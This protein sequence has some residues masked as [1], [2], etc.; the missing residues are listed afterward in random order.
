MDLKNPSNMENENLEWVKFKSMKRNSKKFKIRRK[1]P[2]IITVFIIILGLIII[3]FIFQGQEVK[4]EWFNDSWMY[5]QK[6]TANNNSNFDATDVPYK[7]LVDT[8][9]L[10]TDGKMQSDGD[11]IRIINES[12]QIVRF[13]I[14]EST[15]NTS[16]TGIWFEATI[17]DN[18]SANY[19][20]YYG[21]PS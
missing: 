14:E 19:Y 10:I 18:S 20:L 7:V 16:E 8:S 3:Y 13:Q 2:N 1:L 21:N 17:E 11:D 4:A 9:T 5:R 15:L 6:I 12:G